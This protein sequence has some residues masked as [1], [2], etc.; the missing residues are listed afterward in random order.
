MAW[1]FWRIPESQL[2]LLGPVRG[3]DMLEIGCGAARWLVALRSRGARPVGLD[4]SRRRLEQA[5]DEMRRAHRTFPLVEGDAE[6]LP[7]ADRSFDVVFC[8]WGAMTFCDPTW[9]IPEA[10]RVLRIGGRF[11][12]ATSSPWRVVC[13]EPKRFRLTRRLQRSYF[14]LHRI[15]YNAEVNFVLPYGEW[16][17]RFRENDL[18]VEALLEFQA[19]RG[20][21]TPYLTRSE[22]PWGR[23][24]PLENVWQLRRVE[25]TA[26]GRIPP[27]TRQPRRKRSSSARG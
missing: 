9:T 20:R 5:R 25:P 6:M 3:R 8:D 14:G 27:A 15:T 19:P 22:R 1:G 12:F 10:A 17:R 21:A 26:R 2:R 18:S 7:F 16:I 4:L 13:H 11:V 24:W 23:K